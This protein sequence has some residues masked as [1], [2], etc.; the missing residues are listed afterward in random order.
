MMSAIVHSIRENL[1]FKFI[2]SLSSKC[3][4]VQHALYDHD[5][6]FPH[7]HTTQKSQ[8][9]FI[10][11]QKQPLLARL[12][13]EVGY[14]IEHIDSFHINHIFSKHNNCSVI[15]FFFTYFTHISNLTDHQHQLTHQAVYTFYENRLWYW[16]SIS[17]F[18]LRREQRN[19][20]TK[21]PADKNKGSYWSLICA[22]DVNIN[23]NC[24]WFFICNFVAWAEYMDL[25]SS[26]L[27]VF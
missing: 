18:T 22:T 14:M 11:K 8:L 6:F 16:H 3:V 2:Q 9:L 19:K 27:R 25:T 17:C 5:T 23:S 7:I 26:M 20:R 13:K 24:I 4:K 15:I 12:P 1:H 21:N 10:D